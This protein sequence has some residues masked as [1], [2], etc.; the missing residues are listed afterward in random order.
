MEQDYTSL[1]VGDVIYPCDTGYNEFR[2]AR[3]YNKIVAVYDT[4]RVDD[5]YEVCYPS[6][7]THK[8][9]IL[10][11]EYYDEHDS[12]QEGTLVLSLEKVTINR[13]ILID[14]L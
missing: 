10:S 13:D 4:K 7:A 11:G 14:L 9:V 1:S 2:L 6:N 5:M 8:T 3:S 12:V